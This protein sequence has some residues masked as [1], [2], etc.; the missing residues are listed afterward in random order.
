LIGVAGFVKM[1][2]NEIVRQTLATRVDRWLS[3][4]LQEA[5]AYNK[6]MHGSRFAFRSGDSLRSF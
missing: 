2:F 1:M 4:P 5:S 6:S 3:I